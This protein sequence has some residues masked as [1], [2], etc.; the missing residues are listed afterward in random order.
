[1]VTDSLLAPTVNMIDSKY[2]SGNTSMNVCFLDTAIENLEGKHI[3][4]FTKIYNNDGVL[5]RDSDDLANA[6]PFLRTVSD[7]HQIDK[8]E[9]YF[10]YPLDIGTTTTNVLRGVKLTPTILQKGGEYK[11]KP[12]S[13]DKISGNWRW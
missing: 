1:M 5:G 11:L 3:R 8:Y 2:I 9:S 10:A 13:I 4:Y 7:S 6:F 12:A